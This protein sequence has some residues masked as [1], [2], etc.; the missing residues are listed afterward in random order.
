MERRFLAIP[1]VTER[2]LIRPMELDDAGELLEDYQDAETMQHLTT[3]R[4]TDLDGARAL[5]PGKID[6]DA[7]DGQL[8]LWKVILRESGAVVGDVGPQRD[9]CGGGPEVGLGGR[10]NKAFCHLGLGREAA[11]AA[12]EAGFTQLGLARA[13]AETSAGNAPARRLLDRVGMR[14]RGSAWCPCGV[15]PPGCPVGLT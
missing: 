11:V 3:E 15:P 6:L 13:G 5:V 10:G 8:S 7:A 9:D 14:T 4:P 2:L 12:I 1:L